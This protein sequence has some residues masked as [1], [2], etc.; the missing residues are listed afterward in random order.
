MKDFHRNE[1]WA[2]CGNP[3]SKRRF[4][5]RRDGGLNNP[6]S[7]E[8]RSRAQVQSAGPE[9]SGGKAACPVVW[10][11]GSIPSLI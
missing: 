9:R 8:R 4:L 10:G 7:P 6:R 11:E 1:K 2:H 5:E 3:R